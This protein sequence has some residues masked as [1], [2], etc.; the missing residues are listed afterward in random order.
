MLR[1]RYV[2]YDF[3]FQIQPG[4]S[5]KFYT[6]YKMESNWDYAYVEV[7][8]DGVSYSG[9][10][11]NI[12]T[13]SNPYGNNH[14]NGITGSSNGWVQGRFSLANYVGQTIS[15]RLSYC[16]D[17]YTT[18]EGI[19]FDDISPVN[20]FSGQQ[21]F[22][23]TAQD[24]ARLFSAMPAGSYYYKVR[25]RDA[26]DQWGKFSPIDGVDV[27][28]LPTYIC[29]DANADETVNVSDAISIINYVFLGGVP[30]DPAESADTNCDGKVNVS[31]AVQIINYVFLGGNI[32]CDTDG[33][34]I[35]DCQ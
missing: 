25:A 20:T 26:E 2:Q 16:T 18:E 23:L 12:T 9:I 32:P 29:G 6:W 14:G 35:S 1:D 22:E 4:D 19:Y 21:S 7:S 11:G 28:A 5:L 34:G 17:S 24:T 8:T 31:D 10:P 27:Y 30:P 3:P 15:V 13:T 33:D